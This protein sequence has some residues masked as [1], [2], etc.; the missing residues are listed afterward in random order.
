MKLECRK[1]SILRVLL[2]LNYHESYGHCFR[3]MKLKWAKDIIGVEKSNSIVK[4]RFFFK[5][6]LAIYEHYRVVI[7]IAFLIF[8]KFI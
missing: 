5:S 8:E 2:F 4:Y 6:C 7:N 1:V 3:A